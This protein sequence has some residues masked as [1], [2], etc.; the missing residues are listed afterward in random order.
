MSPDKKT[1]IDI[2]ESNSTLCLDILGYC[3]VKL[4]ITVILQKIFKQSS[5]T[6]FKAIVTILLK[7]MY[8]SALCSLLVRGVILAIMPKVVLDRIYS[9]AVEIILGILFSLRKPNFNKSEVK[10]M[11][12]TIV[13]KK[14]VKLCLVY[15]VLRNTV[16]DIEADNYIFELNLESQAASKIRRKLGKKLWKIGVS[17]FGNMIVHF[18]LEKLA[19]IKWQQLFVDISS[20]CSLT[21]ML[22]IIRTQIFYDFRF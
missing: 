10:D 3:F 16:L 15:L 12:T 6:A 19:K 8:K 2:T 11:T 7:R 13:A 5:T 17:C 18:L 9:V 1:Y 14:F 21:N 4:L 20:T 22:K